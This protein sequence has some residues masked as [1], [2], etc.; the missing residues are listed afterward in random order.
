M[1]TNFSYAYFIARY[2]GCELKPSETLFIQENNTY[3]RFIKRIVHNPVLRVECFLPRPG[4][5]KKLFDKLGYKNTSFR[6]GNSYFIS[7]FDKQQLILKVSDPNDKINEKS[8]KSC[9]AIWIV[10][11]DE[12]DLRRHMNAFNYSFSFNIPR[13]GVIIDDKGQRDLSMSIR[14]LELSS[15]ISL[16]RSDSERDRKEM[17]QSISKILEN[18]SVYNQ[19][20]YKYPA[21]DK[22]L[23]TTGAILLTACVIG[24]SIFAVSK[25]KNRPKLN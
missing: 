5:L 7:N 15:I 24:L 22:P 11:D 8:L 23:A 18:A 4:L 13:I 10:G 20:T 25:L 3:K 16:S 19:S 21:L 1:N 9:N 14:E 12:N 2:L 17:L 6:Q